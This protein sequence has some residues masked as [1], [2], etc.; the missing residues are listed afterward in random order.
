MRTLEKVVGLCLALAVVAGC[1]C[2]GC[3]E[4][5]RWSA[6]LPSGLDYASIR[7]LAVRVCWNGECVVGDF[8]GS[9]RGSATGRGRARSAVV[10]CRPDGHSSGLVDLTREPDGSFGVSIPWSVRRPANG[11]RYLVEITD[12]TGAVVVGLA[13]DP[14]DYAV[15]RANEPLDPTECR[16]VLIE[17]SVMDAGR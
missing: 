12:P 13:E 10:S 7:A 4:T 16:T 14:V 1:T 17:R 8:G 11:D 9:T 2:A 5:F 6:A 3:G 15:Y